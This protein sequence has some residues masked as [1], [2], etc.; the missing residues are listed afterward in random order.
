[1]RESTSAT[2][3]AEQPPPWLHDIDEIAPLD[4]DR[5]CP[6]KKLPEELLSQILYMLG[7]SPSGRQSEGLDKATTKIPKRLQRND[8]DARRLAI[9]HD[10][11]GMDH[12]SIEMAGRVC[13]KLRMMTL[14][15]R[16]W[17]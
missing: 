11:K 17:Q 7:T 8:Q 1:M 15:S 10:S 3:K 4:A 2:S 6:I 13:W 9:D 12:R 5:P 14:D 16:L